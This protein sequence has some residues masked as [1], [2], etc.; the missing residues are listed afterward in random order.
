MRAEGRRDDCCPICKSVV[1]EHFGGTSCILIIVIETIHLPRPFSWAHRASTSVETPL[2]HSTIT[3]GLFLRTHVV[4]INKMSGD[5][6]QRSIT[7]NGRSR[8]RS[9]RRFS[10][11]CIFAR[12]SMM[13]LSVKISGF[14]V[15]DVIYE[16]AEIQI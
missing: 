11:A 12:K 14:L 7:G 3:L 2:P 4:R 10:R 9:N 16:F 6:A 1:F 8:R 13:R 15:F 5:A